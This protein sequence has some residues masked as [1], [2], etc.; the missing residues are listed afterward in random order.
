M[1]LVRTF[2]PNIGVTS[3][4]DKLFEWALAAQPAVL[5]IMGN[6]PQAVRFAEALPDTLIVAREWHSLDGKFWWQVSPEDA[7]GYVM[8]DAQH[9]LPLPQNI[10]MDV[11]NEPSTSPEFP[12]VDL[13]TWEMA[14]VKAFRRAG[15]KY[16]T[17][18]ASAKTI[19]YIDV[20]DVGLWDDLL[21]VFHENGDHA[22]LGT[23]DYT[24]AIPPVDYMDLGWLLQPPMPE[25]WVRDLDF[26]KYPARRHWHL[27]RQESLAHRARELGYD[28]VRF[29]VTECYLDY[30]DDVNKAYKIDDVG[31][32]EYL[33]R[34]TGSNM[35]GTPGIEPYYRM[36]YPDRHPQDIHNACR[37]WI[38]NEMPDYLEGCCVFT[39]SRHQDWVNFALTDADLAHMRDMP[40]VDNAERVAR[41]WQ[42]SE[43]MEY[44]R[45]QITVTAEPS[46][47]VR[48]GAGLSFD[49]V[50]QL[51]AG[52][53]GQYEISTSA[54][55]SDD[56]TWRNLLGVG[57]IAIEFVEI[58]ELPGTV[59][60]DEPPGC[61]PRAVNFVQR[62]LGAV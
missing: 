4:Y 13:L 35:R 2:A 44:E 39:W 3:D 30:M 56:Y 58:D 49:V 8:S 14:A 25:Y 50:G 47:R 60:D 20:Y 24:F 18:F 16:V 28:R 61:R 26:S 48:A 32:G 45:M 1:A 62:L 22:L 36:V 5:L 42:E 52:H 38:H 57:W 51:P 59:P 23:H 40:M 41:W 6:M 43:P 34:L 55:E 15:M 29:V 10:Y 11:N 31:I 37:L 12:L 46:L 17:A 27:F 54:V 21:R 9:H 33:K 19:D 7:V 53:V